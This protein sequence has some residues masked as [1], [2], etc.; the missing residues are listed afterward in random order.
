MWFLVLSPTNLSLYINI[1]IFV[2]VNHFTPPV[3]ARS[4]AT[5]QSHPL[6]PTSF[7]FAFLPLSSR[8][9]HLISVK[10]KCGNHIHLDQHLRIYLCIFTLYV[11]PFYVRRTVPATLFIVF[12]LHLIYWFVIINLRFY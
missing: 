2:I 8:T 6:L 4:E 1:L 10:G 7:V 3:T 12:L 11:I 9:S 5:W